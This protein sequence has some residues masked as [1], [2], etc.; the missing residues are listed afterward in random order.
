MRGLIAVKPTECAHETRC[1]ADQLIYEKHIIMLASHAYSQKNPS[2][3]N[4]L[5]SYVMSNIIQQ[6]ACI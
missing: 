6:T 4:R 1:V 3:E 2:L 5:G